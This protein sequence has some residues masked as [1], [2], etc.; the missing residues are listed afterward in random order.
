MIPN[1]KSPIPSPQSPIPDPQSSRRFLIVLVLFV[2]FR[3]LAILLFRPGG[4]VADFSDRDFYFEWGRLTAGGYRIYEDLWAVYPPLFPAMMLSIFEM[5][6][7]VPP[8]VDNR[9]FFNV[10]L[11]TVLL[12]FETGNLVLIYRL[13]RRIA[14]VDPLWPALLYALCFAPVYTLLGW[15]ESMPLFFLLLGLDLLL[16]RRRWAWM[17]SAVAVALGFL[18]KLTPILL[19][20]VAVR[21]LGAKLSVFAAR[22]EWIN[23][24][25][26]GNLLRPVLYTAAFAV[27]VVAVAYPIV[28]TN[29][30]LALS[31][32]RVQSI[33]PPWQSLWA[34]L[35]GYFSFGLV[36]LDMRNL[37]GLA[38]PLWESRLPWMW[39]S[40]AFVI[41]YAWLYTRPYDWTRPR[42]VVSFTALS[43]TWLFLYSKGWSPQFVIWL[44]AFLVLLLPNLRGVMIGVV[45][46]GINAV[47]AA[48]F[49]IML[50][51]EHWILWGTVLLRTI[52]LIVLAVEFAGQIWP[53]P[54]TRAVRRAAAVLAWT[55]MGV[56]LIAAVVAL[57]RAAVAYGERR[58]AENPC[59]GVVETLQDQAA[60]PSALVATES[61]Q[62]WEWLYPWLRTDY[63]IYVVD[64]YS[65]DRTAA[66]VGAERLAAQ[67]TGQP[68]FWWVS[69]LGSDAAETSLQ[70]QITAHFFDDPAVTVLETQRHGACALSRVAQVPAQA[71]AVADV[72]GGP[73]SLLAAQT[74]TAQPGKTL[75][76]VLYWQ[77]ALRVDERYTVFTQLT[78]PDGVLIAQQDNY[79]VR[80][81]APT[82]TWPPDVV[83]RDPYELAVP[84][85]AAPGVYE[86]HIGLYTA[87]GRRPLVRGDGTAG[88][89]VTMMIEIGRLGD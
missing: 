49:L 24:R 20:P 45:L 47:E 75:H 19:I 55:T 78:S 13:A 10:F 77:A 66:E 83:V 26:P 58:L 5:A 61:I 81:L 44:L 84:A 17:G 38:G 62:A 41:L 4:F 22:R 3:L 25:S 80:G 74:G 37:A 30:D 59:V 51:N 50:P 21:V 6:A 33:R 15:F 73:I 87:E 82:D 16:M 67:V 89:F 64:G 57:P 7:R 48:G 9:L 79:P 12:V 11:S 29:L 71:L 35:D 68:E 76:V 60:W 40:L 46:T 27:T 8:W 86:L 63:D 18:T 53:S 69:W 14:V 42:T 65:P 23:R 70:T 43:V 72:A 1:P 2:S 39:I 28:G 56:S 34:V 54:R 32:F 88:D 85:G 52:L 36:P 31:S